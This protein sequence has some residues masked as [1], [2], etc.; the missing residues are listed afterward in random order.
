MQHHHDIVAMLRD[1]EEN[2][3]DSD[4]GARY[5]QGFLAAKVAAVAVLCAKYG[6]G[7]VEMLE[8]LMDSRNL[9]GEISLLVARMEISPAFVGYVHSDLPF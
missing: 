2:G 3:F 5:E 7:E 4:Q 8:A 1:L 6:A 9:S